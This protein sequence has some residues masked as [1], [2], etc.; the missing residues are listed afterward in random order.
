M[1]KLLLSLASVALAMTTASAQDIKCYMGN[2]DLLESGKTYEFNDIVAEQEGDQY[3]V[4]MDPKMY[5]MCDQDVADLYVNAKC[6]S[7]H[8]IG[9]CCGSTCVSGTDVTKDGLT[10]VAN[11]KFNLD[12]DLKP[13]N[14]EVVPEN[15][16]TE[17][18]VGVKDKAETV[19]SYTVIMNSKS[20]AVQLVKNANALSYMNGSILY[21]V[22]KPGRLT[23]WNANGQK[24]IEKNI[25]NNGTVSLKG[26]AKGIYLYSLAGDRNSARKIIVK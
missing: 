13:G 23:V 2:G 24:V 21:N 22:E 1:K 3:W 9:L 12:F 10:M 16:T 17:L 26:L 7:G 18:T 5:L 11:T 14:Y 19:K 6:T 20:S 25:S 15:V 4:E 8:Q